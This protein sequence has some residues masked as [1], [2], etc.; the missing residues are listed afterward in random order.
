MCFDVVDGGEDVELEFLQVSTGDPGVL[1]DSYTHVEGLKAVAVAVGDPVDVVGE[2]IDHVH[3][4]H[5][6]FH[7]PKVA[8]AKPAS[9]SGAG[10]SILGDTG[11]Y[12]L[13][14]VEIRGVPTCG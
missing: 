2:L 7:H 3:S 6:P 11:S 4:S 5:L 13:Y 12:S 1:L 9:A 14:A 10:C 8:M